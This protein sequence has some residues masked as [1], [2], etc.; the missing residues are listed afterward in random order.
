MPHSNSG[1]RKVARSLT[2]VISLQSA[3]CSPPPWH[4]P[5]TADTTGFTD[6]RS[7]SV[8][9]GVDMADRIADPEVLRRG[10]CIARL[11]PVERADAECPF[12]GEPRYGVP[13][14]SPSG[15]RGVLVID[16]FPPPLDWLRP[17]RWRR[18]W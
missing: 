13:S 10:H 6:W 14:Q 2:T 7:V 15:G 17:R 11:R 3:I 18:R 9:I 4:S 1:T 12:P 8:G 16:T 5:L